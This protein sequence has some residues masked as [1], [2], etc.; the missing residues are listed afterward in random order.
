MFR[1]GRVYPRAMR[2]CMCAQFCPWT[3]SLQAPLFMGFSRQEYWSGLPFP[4]PGD[5]LE[6]GIEPSSLALQ[7]ESLPFESPGKPRLIKTISFTFVPNNCKLEH[8]RKCPGWGRG[9]MTRRII[10]RWMVLKEWWAV[11]SRGSDWH[12]TPFSFPAKHHVNQGL[13]WNPSWWLV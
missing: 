5:L 3:I 6:Q 9:T 7:A 10:S 13:F 4:S 12:Q 2:A 11:F 1:S 8:C